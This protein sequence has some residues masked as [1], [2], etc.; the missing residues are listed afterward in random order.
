V[1]SKVSEIS[2][3]PFLTACF[4]VVVAAFFHIFIFC[5]LFIVYRVGLGLRCESRMCVKCSPREVASRSGLFAL[6][7]LS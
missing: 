1:I 5:V 2:S 3:R 6:V 7:P 4:F